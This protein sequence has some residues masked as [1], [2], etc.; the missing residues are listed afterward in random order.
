MKRKTPALSKTIKRLR[1]LQ[2]NEVF[3][4]RGTVTLMVVGTTCMMAYQGKIDS[5]SFVQIVTLIVTFW[6]VSAPDRKRIT[7]APGTDET[8]QRTKP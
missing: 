4:V 1:F 2:L 3:S 8:G 7:D 6:F 5:A